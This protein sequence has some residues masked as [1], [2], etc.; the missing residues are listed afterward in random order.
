MRATVIHYNYKPIGT[1]FRARC[2]CRPSFQPTRS[3]KDDH[4][5]TCHACLKK[6]ARRQEHAASEKGPFS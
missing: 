1:V 5:V 6:L 2:Y 4:K 3:T